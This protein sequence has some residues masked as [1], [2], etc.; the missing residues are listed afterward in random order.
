MDDFE[1]WPFAPV[2]NLPESFQNRWWAECFLPTPAYETLQNQPHWAVIVGGVGCG[3]SI[4]LRALKQAK[5]PADIILDLSA[6]DSPRQGA[7]SET[8]LFQDIMTLAAREFSYRFSDEPLLLEKISSTQ[9]E[10][11]RWLI[12]KFMGRR[13]YLVFL[14]GL[15]AGARK[16]MEAVDFIELY[17]TQTETLDVQGQITELCNLGKSLG[18]QNILVLVDTVSYASKEQLV[19]LLDYLGWLEPMH[20]RGFAVIVAISQTLFEIYKLDA[21]MRGRVKIISVETS[22]QG[23]YAVVGKRLLA[24]TADKV[25]T[26]EQIADKKLLD[27]LGK[28]IELEFGALSPGPLVNLTELLLD[29]NQRGEKLDEQHF[30]R[31]RERFYLKYLPL[32]LHAQPQRLGVWRGHRFIP[33]DAGVYELLQRLAKSGVE[34]WGGKGGNEYLHTLASRLRKAIEPDPKNPFY[35]QNRRNEGYWLEG[36]AEKQPR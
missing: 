15:D 24:A 32:R 2:D 4:L 12:E 14:D 13:P 22:P 28:M 21:L 5:N 36:L 25:Q 16:I 7:G 17:A 29:L 18:S 35:L 26:L 31:V 20:H 3:K 27:S 6:A 11:V 34:S 8:S 23:T 1:R 19:K 9:R 10:Y 30:E 33:L